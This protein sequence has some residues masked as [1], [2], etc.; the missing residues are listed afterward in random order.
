[1]TCALSFIFRLFQQNL[2]DVYYD[3]ETTHQHSH[4]QGAKVTAKKDRR[5][6]M[7]FKN[8]EM[9]VIN[10]HDDENINKKSMIKIQLPHFKAHK[11]LPKCYFVKLYHGLDRARY[12][13]EW[14]IATFRIIRLYSRLWPNVLQNSSKM[15]EW[16]NSFSKLKRLTKIRGELC[17]SILFIEIFKFITRTPD[18]CM[19]CRRL[20]RY[21]Q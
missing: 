4:R 1:M 8:A 3:G 5:I 16:R 17:A 21:L 2:L 15:Q 11:Y 19:S 10:L 7:V 14:S 6:Y 9:I 12:V 13:K 20:F 18:Q